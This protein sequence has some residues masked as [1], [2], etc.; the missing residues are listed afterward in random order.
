MKERFV[1][2]GRQLH[3]EYKDVDE[4]LT[5]VHGKKCGV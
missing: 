5:S 1:D 2:G 3:L 4:I